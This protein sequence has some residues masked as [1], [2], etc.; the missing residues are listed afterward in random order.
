VRAA[1]H[2]AKRGN[3]F[4]D[5]LTEACKPVRQWVDI[6]VESAGMPVNQ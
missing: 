1:E 4:G 6:Q 3:D 2:N 5:R